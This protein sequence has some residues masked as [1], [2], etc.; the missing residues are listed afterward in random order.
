MTAER[1]AFDGE[2]AFRHLEHLAVDIG[3]RL[4]GSA[5][6]HKAARYVARQFRSF[7]LK[8]TQ[9]R[10]DS[11]TF[12]N[13]KC[14]FEVRQGGR[15]RR[16]E[17]EPVMLSES[18]PAGG[19]EGALY[20]AQTGQ[21]EY[22][23]P[24]MK[25]KIVLVCGA[26]TAEDR[27]RAVGYGAKA[28]VFIDPVVREN[29]RRTLLRVES[30]RTYGDLPMATIRHMDGLE[31]IRRGAGRCRLVLR[32]SE[33]KSYSLNV[34]GQK[35]GTDFAEKYLRRYVTD[36]PVFPFVREISEDQMKDI[37]KYFDKGKLP[38]PGKEPTPYGPK[39]QPR[40]RS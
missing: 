24:E 35:A 40:R 6:E 8:V 14:G 39:T 13:R 32:N 38:I 21:G 26:L 28:I 12:S 17:A 33:K 31:I 29:F 36:A 15:W 22:L 5:G 30:R 20:D 3:P 9:Q 34:I 37:E 27:H 25:G 18:T 7:G 2:K 11:T 23:T 4:T 10:F 19:V 16:L 1:M